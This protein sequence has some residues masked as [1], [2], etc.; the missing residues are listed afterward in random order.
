MS[1]FLTEEK[2]TM[3]FDYD[4]FLVNNIHEYFFNFATEGMFWYSSILAYMFTFFQEN[5]FSFSMQKMDQDG[6][7]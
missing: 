5:R 2:P 1:I 7:P 4:T 3:Q 6:K